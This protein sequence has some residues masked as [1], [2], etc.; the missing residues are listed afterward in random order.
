MDLNHPNFMK[1]V[2]KDWVVPIDGPRGVVFRIKIWSV[3][4]I[5]L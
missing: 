3:F 5:I 4:V 1:L 2:E